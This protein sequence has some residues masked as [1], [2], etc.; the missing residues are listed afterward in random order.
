[1]GLYKEEVEAAIAY[2]KEAVRRRGIHAI[3]NFDLAEYIDLLGAF[4]YAQ[5][6]LLQQAVL[7]I[8]LPLVQIVLRTVCMIHCQV[9]DHINRAC[10]S[11]A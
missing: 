2:D 10:A 8:T 9:C 7:I 4:C 1:M 3:T 5:C 6:V 11:F